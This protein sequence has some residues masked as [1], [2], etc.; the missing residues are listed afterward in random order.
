MTLKKK[1]TS[2]RSA[3]RLFKI[4]LIVDASLG[5]GSSVSIAEYLGT[6]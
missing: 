5:A 3:S 4:N 6:N 2:D 1:K